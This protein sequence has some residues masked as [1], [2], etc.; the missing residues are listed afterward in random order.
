MLGK[1]AEIKQARQKQGL[2]TYIGL[3]GCVVQA[4]G[5]EVFKKAHFLDL[6]V[7]PQ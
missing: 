6:A 2:T 5:D 7:G 4:L 1:F 3:A